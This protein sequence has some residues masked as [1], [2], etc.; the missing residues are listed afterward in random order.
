MLLIARIVPEEYQHARLAIEMVPWIRHKTNQITQIIRTKDDL[1]ELQQ[2][3]NV[4][5]VVVGL[6]DNFNSNFIT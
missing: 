6:F 2:Q 5:G 4:N 3:V 1:F